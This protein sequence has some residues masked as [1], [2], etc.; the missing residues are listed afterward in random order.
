MKKQTNDEHKKVSIWY[1]FRAFGIFLL[2]SIN[3]LVLLNAGEKY[4]ALANGLAL[5]GY[6]GDILFNGDY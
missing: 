5:S 6:L 4:L 2:L 1:K 3:A